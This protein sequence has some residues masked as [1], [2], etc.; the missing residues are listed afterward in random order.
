[1]HDYRQALEIAIAF[2]ISA[3]AAGKRVH[4]PLNDR[5]HTITPAPW[6]MLGGDVAGWLPG[7]DPKIAD[8]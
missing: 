2:K 6:R 4:L 3:R 5:G 8:A 1:G 7:L